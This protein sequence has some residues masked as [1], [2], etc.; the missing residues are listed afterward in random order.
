MEFID[1][2]EYGKVIVN[3]YLFDDKEYIIVNTPKGMIEGPPYN[4]YRSLL[5]IA[6]KIR[7]EY[8]TLGLGFILDSRP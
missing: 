7:G 8:E 3:R 1:K 4:V 2:V 6:D 5:N